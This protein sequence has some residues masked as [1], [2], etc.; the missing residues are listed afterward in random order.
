MVRQRYGRLKIVL[1]KVQ[2]QF[3]AP[4]HKRHVYRIGRVHGAAAGGEQE[5]SERTKYTNPY[6]FFHGDLLADP[7][8]FIPY[9]KEKTCR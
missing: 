3:S 6:N 4:G 9:K 1:V 5:C 8:S 2:L 7:S